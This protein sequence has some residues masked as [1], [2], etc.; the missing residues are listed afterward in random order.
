MKFKSTLILTALMGMGATASA[1]CGF[2]SVEQ[3]CGEYSLICAML[4]DDDDVNHFAMSAVPGEN[5]NEIIFQRFYYIDGYDV[6]ATVDLEAGTV[7]FHELNDFLYLD[8]Y[9]GM[10][11]FLLYKWNATH[12]RAN[13]VPEMT[14]TIVPDGTGT[15]VFDPDYYF[16]IVVPDGVKPGPNGPSDPGYQIVNELGSIDGTTMHFQPKNHEWIYA[17]EQWE[18]A[19][20]AEFTGMWIAPL[21]GFN[22]GDNTLT[23][24]VDYFENKANPE[25]LLLTNPYGKHTPWSDPESVSAEFLNT[26][27]EPGYYVID[28]TDPDFVLVLYGVNVGYSSKEIPTIQ[29]M[30]E[31]GYCVYF[32][33]YDKA[34]S[35]YV[36]NNFNVFTFSVRKGNDITIRNLM[37]I[38]DKKYYLSESSEEYITTIKLFPGEESNGIEELTSVNAGQSRYFNL[39]GIEVLNPEKGQILIERNAAGSRKIMVK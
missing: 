8:N 4:H 11:S 37:Y 10:S 25:M 35:K 1:N 38:T 6:P 13:K 5:E 34:T 22:N 19:G 17:P 31:E 24:K 21:A 28:T 12:T 32:D 26:S 9:E 15:I 36:L 29:C 39:Q 3:L 23:Y 33:G 20:Q 30:N 7:T 14:G 18:Y 27:S 16:S 2:T